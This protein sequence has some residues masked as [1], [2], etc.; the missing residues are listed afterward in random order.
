MGNLM[1]L[2]QIYQERISKIQNSLKL[3]NKLK[4]YNWGGE[5]NL[6]H[7]IRRN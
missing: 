4:K 3:S 6:E 2:R 5:P 1:G 7:Q